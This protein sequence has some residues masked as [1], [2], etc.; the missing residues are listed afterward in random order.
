MIFC[1]FC[2]KNF[3]KYGILYIINSLEDIALKIAVIDTETTLRNEVMSI[4]VAIADP[5][6]FSLIAQRYLTITPRINDPAMYSTV[7]YI[8]RPDIEAS[9]GKV[10]EALEDFLDRHN[11]QKLFAYN[12]SFDFAHLPELRDREW[13]DIM[14]IAAYKQFNKKIPSG[15]ECGPSGRLKRGY[16]VESIYIMLSGDASY[17]EKHNALTDAVDELAI[18]RMLNVGLERYSAAKLRPHNNS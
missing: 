7:R 8:I 16:G 10:I 3:L 18:M 14:R 2:L 11:V 12:A 15:A 17:R 9:R 1:S 13:F 5:D 4:G 6:G